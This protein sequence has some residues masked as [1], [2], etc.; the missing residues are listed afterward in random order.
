MYVPD[1]SHNLLS[2]SKAASNGKSFE[3]GQSHC[4]IIDNKFGIIAIATKCRNLYYL[5]CAGSKLS[6]KEN[7]AAMKCASTD[8]TKESI[9]RRR[10]EHLGA[11]NLERTA[12]KQLVAGF[13]Y[14]PKKESSF[15]EPCVGGKQSTLPFPKTGGERSDELLGIF[16]S[17]VCGKIETKPLSGAEY[18]LTFINDK[19]RFVWVY[20][21]KH[22]SEIFEK[23]T[24][25]K[26]MVEKSSGMKV[27]VQRTD[28]GGEHTSKEFEQYLKK[29]GT[30]HELTAPKTPQQHGVAERM[31]RTLVEIIRSILTDSELPKRFWAEVLSTA[32]YLRKRSPTNVVQDKTPYEAWTGN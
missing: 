10:Y 7:H 8:Q 2:V 13:D 21:L 9:W 3:F 5:N 18:F 30:Q 4:N 28:H 23:F 19:S 25:W 29:Q 31:N 17:D 20:T 14:E 12:K 15:S 16:H 1:L 26:S 24:D 32:T 6:V 22:K 11:R 27:K